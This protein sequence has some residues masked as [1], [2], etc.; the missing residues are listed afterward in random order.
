MLSRELIPINALTRPGSQ[1]PVSDGL[2]STLKLL[3]LKRL[4]RAAQTW[5]AF[6]SEIHI[7]KQALLYLQEQPQALFHICKTRPALPQLSQDGST[8][9]FTPLPLVLCHPTET[10]SCLVTQA[11]VSAELSPIKPTPIIQHPTDD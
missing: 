8:L 6:F 11:E 1:I 10:D 7:S 3:P 9:S 5:P 2:R 4:G